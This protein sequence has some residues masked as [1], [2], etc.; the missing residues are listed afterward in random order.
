MAG[1]KE[2]VAENR[3]GVGEVA[4]ET[5]ILGG[6]GGEGRRRRLGDGKREGPGRGACVSF[7]VVVWCSAL[8]LLW[9]DSLPCSLLSVWTFLSP[10]FLSL[11]MYIRPCLVDEMKSFRLM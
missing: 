4:E 8:P 7:R 1:V 9:M 2:A 6:G 11:L 3:M 10:V 5:E